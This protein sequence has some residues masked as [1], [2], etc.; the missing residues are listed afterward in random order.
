MQLAMKKY[1]ALGTA[2]LMG[3]GVMLS[4]P[5]AQQ[6]EVAVPQLRSPAIELTMVPWYIGLANL[7]IGVAEDL[8]QIAIDEIN[9]PLPIISQILANQENNL[10]TIVGG[11]DDGLDPLIQTAFDIP[12][13]A[14]GIVL[15][16]II[17][18]AALPTALAIVVDQLLDLPGE[19]LG[20]ILGAVNEVVQTTIINAIQVGVV[21]ADDVPDL[22]A[23]TLAV[24]V[25]IGS[26][27]LAAGINVVNTAVNNPAAVPNAIGNGVLAVATTTVDQVGGV[28]ESVGDTRQDI[29]D[30]LSPS[31]VYSATVEE[32]AVEEEAPVVEEESVETRPG[33]L[34]LQQRRNNP[35]ED[36]ARVVRA[37]NRSGVL[38]TETV[39]LAGNRVAGEVAEA[40]IEVGA[41]VLS[42]NQRLIRSAVASGHQEI[43]EAVDQGR[44][45]VGASVRRA[46]ADIGNAIAGDD[47]EAS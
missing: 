34:M 6:A 39:L 16:A 26:T 7:G 10:G 23:Q 31:M 47:S 37:I 43:S 18:P 46:G 45:E 2:A 9:D 4:V 1:A 32:A 15:V 35:L 21:L 40:G 29:V 30:A 22:I 33:I 27:A 12:A 28:V 8:A 3:A 19:V 36:G 24:P 25:A 17:N 11:F 13:A 42:G 38:V 44:D 41:A 14:A 20:P 5:L